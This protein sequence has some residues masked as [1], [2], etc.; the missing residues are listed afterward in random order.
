MFTSNHLLKAFLSSGQRVCKNE[1]FVEK[2]RA[3]EVKQ[4]KLYS[5]NFRTETVT[6]NHFLDDLLPLDQKVCR[7]DNRN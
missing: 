5:S 7:V 2:K 4:A 1:V 6:L 3:T